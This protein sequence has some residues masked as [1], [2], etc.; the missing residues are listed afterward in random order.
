MNRLA[1]TTLAVALISAATSAHAD[2]PRPAAGRSP[3]GPDD[4]IGRLNLM[5]EASRAAVL[6]RIAGGR[7]YDL[8]VEYHKEMPSWHLL[9]DPTYQIWMTHTP[10]GT[11]VDNVLKLGSAMHERVS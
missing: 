11:K 3:W 4:Q 8:G 9:G 5:T 2:S 6:G 7:L 10:Q 1:A